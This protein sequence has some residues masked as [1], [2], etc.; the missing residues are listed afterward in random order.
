MRVL[1]RLRLRAGVLV[2]RQEE[3]APPGQHAAPDRK[4]PAQSL[5]TGC[6]STGVIFK[7]KTVR[8]KPVF[9]LILAICA[10]IIAQ[11]A[12][13]QPTLACSGLT[14]TLVVHWPQFGFT[15]C[16]NRF[17]PNEFI[18]SPTTVQNLQVKW[19]TL[20]GYGGGASPA[21]VDGVMYIDANDV[22][23]VDYLY[24]VNANTGMYLWSYAK[25]SQTSSSPAVANGLVFVGGHD[26]AVFAVH[27]QTG[28][29]A[30]KFATG[31]AV[32]GAPSVANGIVYV[33][34]WDGNM[35][36]LDAATG[37][38]LWT[39]P[40]GSFVMGTPAI[41]AG[42]AYIP[43]GNSA[44]LYAVDAKTGAPR[45]SVNNGSSMLWSSPAVANG[46][47]YA[48][49]DDASLY[50]LD[51]STGALRWKSGL[52]GINMTS[53]AVANGLV[54]VGARDANNNAA[55]YCV[56]ASTGA[57]VWKVLPG[58]IGGPPSSP[59]VA[60]GVVY[61]VRG[62][63]QAY[64]ASTGAMLWQYNEGSSSPSVVNGVL[65]VNSATGPYAFH[66]P[67]QH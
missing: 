7:E 23:G 63:S 43:A 39:Q 20:V 65:Y 32:W 35:Y 12:V 19:R 40:V 36:A 3:E 62:G 31:N 45:W 48:G 21:V 28:T 1:L 11:P 59:V 58:G 15:S 13:A 55:L 41:A 51:A 8:T 18:L 29:L 49:M 53:I 67:N 60:N 22:H 52:L 14:H 50:A 54:Y 38:Q 2:S 30:W 25:G 57:V 47:V 10:V 44:S 56:N 42:V 66:L 4:Q 33:I 5:L 37:T 34:S 17:N 27:A 24:A 46:I 9:A 26:N 16:G 6:T 61:I 64:D